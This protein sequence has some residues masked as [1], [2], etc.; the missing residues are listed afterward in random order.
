M[1]F[2]ADPDSQDELQPSSSKASN[3]AFKFIFLSWFIK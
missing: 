1:A 3:D 2:N